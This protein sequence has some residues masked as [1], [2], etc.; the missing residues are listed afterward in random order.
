MLLVSSQ[1]GLLFSALYCS[2][3]ICSAL[4]SIAVDLGIDYLT[5]LSNSILGPFLNYAIILY[6]ITAALVHLTAAYLTATHFALHLN[7]QNCW[8]QT[9]LLQ[10]LIYYQSGV[11]T[12]FGCFY[13]TAILSWGYG[14]GWVE[15]DVDLN[16]RLKWG[17]DEIESKFS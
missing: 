8:H 5:S 12:R 6:Y 1:C 4:D 16:L 9:W 3:L 7:T 14:W 15:V 10:T 13:V 17:W 2:T 11:K